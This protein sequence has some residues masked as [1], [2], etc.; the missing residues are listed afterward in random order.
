MEI[1]YGPNGNVS[2]EVFNG[3]VSLNGELLKRGT[4]KIMY[5]FVIKV[6]QG[7]VLSPNMFKKFLNEHS[8]LF[9]KV[10]VNSVLTFQQTNIGRSYDYFM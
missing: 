3:A 1:K 6:K 8:N 7:D 5:M 2:L 4:V 9:V 10:N